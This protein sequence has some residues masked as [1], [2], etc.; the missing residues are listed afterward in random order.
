MVWSEDLKRFWWRNSLCEWIKQKRKTFQNPCHT[1][2]AAPFSVGEHHQAGASLLSCV[3]DPPERL[4][5]I[6]QDIDNLRTELEGERELLQQ[7][8]GFLVLQNLILAECTREQ[9]DLWVGSN[10]TD[11]MMFA[12]LQLCVSTQRLLKSLQLDPFFSLW[13]FFFFFLNAPQQTSSY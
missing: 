7:H 11:S 6:Q 2:T 8:V 10:Q 4:S 12:E 5:S 1:L 13:V 3:R 9:L